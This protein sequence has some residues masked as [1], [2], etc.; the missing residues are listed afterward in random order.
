M[1][2][3][4]A[5]GT[6][7]PSLNHLIF[8]SAYNGDKKLY[9]RVIQDLAGNLRR[10]PKVILEMPRSARHE[11]FQ[12]LMGLPAFEVLAQ[13]LIIHWLKQERS[14]MV[15][16]FLDAL[17]IAHDGRGFADEFPEEVPQAKLKAAVKTLLKEYPEEEVAFYL[18]IFDSL[19]GTE[20]DGLE[21]L[22]PKP[23]QEAI[24]GQ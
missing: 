5:W 12:P 17:G 11:L 7:S 2:C 13:N 8:E 15:I 3:T 9:R 1:Y 19:T 16:A 23:N 4:E 14:G 22:I 18:N 24:K 10:R 20:W 6:I 21:E